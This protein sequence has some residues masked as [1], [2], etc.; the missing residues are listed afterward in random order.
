MAT[1]TEQ[2]DTGLRAVAWPAYAAGSLMIA[3]SLLD[4]VANVWPLQ[5]GQLEW[6]YGAWG[7]LSGYALTPLLGTVM[8]AAAAAIL[9]HRRALAVLFW[10]YLLAAVLLI[11][12]TILFVL[13]VVQLRAQV[14]SGEQVRFDTGA[15][16]AGAKHLLVA[17]ALVWLGR[18]CR[19]ASRQAAPRR[20]RSDADV[21]VASPR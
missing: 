16:K 18:G 19:S 7:I 13:D 12:G 10:L 17:A 21:L 15:W 14:P 9:G 4:Y 5:P 8:V 11:A 20:S 1:M 2:A 3:L 6:R